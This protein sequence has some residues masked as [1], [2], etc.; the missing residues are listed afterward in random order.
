MYCKTKILRWM[1]EILFLQTEIKRLIEKIINSK[2]TTCI[3]L[4]NNILI[5]RG[6]W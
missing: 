1:N 4:S 5:I 6:N 3:W 2:V